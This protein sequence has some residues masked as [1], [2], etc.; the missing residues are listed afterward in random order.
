MDIDAG[1]DIDASVD[2]GRSDLGTADAEVDAEVPVTPTPADDGGC[3]CRAA[4]HGASSGTGAG[5]F[6][7][8]ALL[9]LLGRAARRRR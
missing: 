1:A 7:C 3:S 8:V 6:A 2:A 9:A 5:L 4:G